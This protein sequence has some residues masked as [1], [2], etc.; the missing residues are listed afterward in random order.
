MKTIVIT[1]VTSGIGKELVRFF[2]SK[3]EQVIGIGRN[4]EKLSS[5]QTEFKEMGYEKFYSVKADF[6]VLKEVEEAGKKIAS[7]FPKGIDVLIHNAAII[8]QVKEITIDKHEMQFQVNY[9][10]AVQLTYCL[11]PLLSLKKGIV[12]TTTSMI[13]KVAHFNQKNIEAT[14]PYFLL[15]SYAKTKLYNILFARGMNKYIYPS[16]GIYTFT[17]DPGLVKTGIMEK[18]SNSF[19]RWAFRSFTSGGTRPDQIGE[20]YGYLVYDCE[21]GN[22]YAYCNKLPKKVSKAA[23]SDKARDLLWDKTNRMLSISYPIS[24]KK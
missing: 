8:P 4:T 5:I 13:H 24:E 2:L 19:F 20:N 6:S 18:Y 12:I 11:I 1:G 15:K 7:E 16:T 17:I 21:I 23:S 3:G 14:R 9:L 22:H 10:A